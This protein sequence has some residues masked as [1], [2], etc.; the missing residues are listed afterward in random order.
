MP[1]IMALVLFTNIFVHCSNAICGTLLTKN[2]LQYVGAFR[3]P[4]TRSGCESW[5]ACVLSYG[6]FT[7]AHNPDGDGGAGSLFVGGNRVYGRTSE[8]SIPTPVKNVSLSDLPVA[9]FLNGFFDVTKGFR[10]NIAENGE[11]YSDSVYDGGLLVWGDKLISSVYA[12]YGNYAQYRSHAVSSLDLSQSTGFMGMLQVGPAGLGRYI[13]G[14]MCPIPPEHRNEFGGKA[15]TGVGGLSVLSTTSVGPSAWVFDPDDLGVTI[16]APAT[17]IVYYPLNHSVYPAATGNDFFTEADKLGGIAFPAGSDSILFFGR[18]GEGEYAYGTPTADPA[19]DGLPVGDGS[20]YC[21]SPGD[22]GFST[23]GP[24]LHPYIYRVWAYSATELLSVKDGT[25]NP[26]DARPY[27]MWELTLPFSTGSGVLGGVTYD[28][29][30][31]RLYIAQYGA[32]KYTY[33]VNPIIHVFSV[34]TPSGS[35]VSKTPVLYHI[36]GG[37]TYGIVQ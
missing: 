25:K 28:Q 24:C 27:A 2:D 5:D 19:L 17:P 29:S 4:M 7:L 31:G 26:W 16:P 32:D 14:Y 30:S 23:K 34:G 21:Y 35:V 6:G 12:N 33:T 10:N 15:L 11:I 18:H 20:S 13:G 36:P 37:V 9:N 1:M 22:I 8:V 3:L